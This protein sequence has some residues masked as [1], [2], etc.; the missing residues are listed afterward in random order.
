MQAV[1]NRVEYGL[2]AVGQWFAHT[3]SIPRYLMFGMLLAAFFIGQGVNNGEATKHAVTSVQTQYQGKLAYHLK[4]EKVVAKA[5][6]KAADACEHN[7]N[8]A[9]NHDAGDVKGCPTVPPVVKAI[10]SEPSK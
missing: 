8:A 4:N 3:Q 10:A 6:T 9:L 2:A 5:A 7:L 1:P